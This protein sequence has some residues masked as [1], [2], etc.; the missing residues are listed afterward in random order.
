MSDFNCCSVRYCFPSCANEDIESDEDM[1]ANVPL[2]DEPTKTVRG[3]LS[4]DVMLG[5]EV[6]GA[7]SNGIY[8]GWAVGNLW[9]LNFVTE[10]IGKYAPPAVTALVTLI[11]S[12]LIGVN[13]ALRCSSGSSGAS[14]EQQKLLGQGQHSGNLGREDT[15]K[16]RFLPLPTSHV[17]S[18]TTQ[19]TILA[20]TGYGDNFIQAGQNAK[21]PNTNVEG[22]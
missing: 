10:N 21:N 12:A 20:S 14:G 11:C 5:V 19:P 15:S 1:E 3:C 4:N 6:T 17:D 9:P 18:L 2:P 8:T 7:I 13:F 16:S 22:F